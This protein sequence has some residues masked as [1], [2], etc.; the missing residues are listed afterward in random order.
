MQ[1][2]AVFIVLSGEYIRA[3]NDPNYSPKETKVGEVR[4]SN[5]RGAYREAMKEF[6]DECV[7]VVWI[8]DE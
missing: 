8:A 4:A 3:N 6:P 1:R 2:F 7:N 5:E